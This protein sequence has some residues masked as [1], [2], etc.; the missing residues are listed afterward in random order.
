LQTCRERSHIARAGRVKAE[1]GEQTLKVKDSAKRAP[2]LLALEQFSMSL[3]HSLVASLQHFG[4]NQRSQDGCSQKP[5]AHGRLA[6]VKRVKQG[7]PVI[8]ADKQRLDKFKIA[9]GHLVQF[10]RC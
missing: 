10:E 2:H 8:L 9:D 7:S 3:A 5:F 1:P 4:I 6:L